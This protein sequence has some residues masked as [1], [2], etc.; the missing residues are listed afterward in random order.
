MATETKS[1]VDYA[2]IYDHLSTIKDGASAAAFIKN[3]IDV[4]GLE[5]PEKEK[6]IKR[7]NAHFIDQFGEKFLSNL[8]LD[9]KHDRDWVLRY[10]PFESVRLPWGTALVILA[11]DPALADRVFLSM[12]KQRI[13]VNGNEHVHL[14]NISAK[15]ISSNFITLGDSFKDLGV[16]DEDGGKHFQLIYRSLFLACIQRRKN[17]ILF[18]LR[19]A[20]KH[21]LLLARDSNDSLLDNEVCEALH[22]YYADTSGTVSKRRL[23]EAQRDVA[24]ET[25]HILIEYIEWDYPAGSLTVADVE[26]LQSLGVSE[27]RLTT[28]VSDLTKRVQRYFKPVIVEVAAAVPEA[29]KVVVA[30]AKVH[31]LKLSDL[32]AALAHFKD[33]SKIKI[34]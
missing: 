24:L 6:L 16:S 20:F 19:I 2:G 12:F 18:G 23:E 15:D 26:H 14:A 22:L 17:D 10:I 7:L 11:A 27:S 5:G 29:V 31:E 13:C 9:H 1:I 30:E 25:L 21:F 4:K 8:F 33:I 32:L 3:S 28:Q 34:V